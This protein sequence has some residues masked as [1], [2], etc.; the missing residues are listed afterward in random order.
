MTQPSPDP[1]VQPVRAAIDS[2]VMLV[3]AR[4]LMP[5][6]VAA[7]GYL[8]TSALDDLKHTNKELW[9]QLGKLNDVQQSANQVQAGLVA[10]VDGVMRQ[11]DR[12]QNQVDGQGRR[13]N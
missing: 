3:L 7:L 12:L 13:P 4:F 11:V 8:M 1:K 10:K 5:V 2:T 9:V 6:V